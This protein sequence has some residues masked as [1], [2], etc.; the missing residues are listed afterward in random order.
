MGLSLRGALEHAEGSKRGGQWCVVLTSARARTEQGLRAIEVWV[1]RPGETV[2]IV[3][4][5][6]GALLGKQRRYVVHHITTTPAS[7]VSAGL[8]QF[9]IVAHTPHE[10]DGTHS[11]AGTRSTVF[12]FPRADRTPTTSSNGERGRSGQANDGSRSLIAVSF[13]MAFIPPPSSC[14][15]RLWTYHDRLA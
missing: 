11:S 4:V 1:R 13:Q 9:V 7:N 2:D 14:S 8:N 5:C 6:V 3:C 12:G 10:V 15:T